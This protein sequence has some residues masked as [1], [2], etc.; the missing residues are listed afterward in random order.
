[1]ANLTRSPS[2]LKQRL[3]RYW[4]GYP[5]WSSGARRNYKSE[6]ERGTKGQMAPTIDRCHSPNATEKG[7][8]L[9]SAWS[10]GH[11][12]GQGRTTLTGS[13]GRGSA[14]L[15]GSMDEGG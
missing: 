7:N 6:P 8:G 3:P 2:P 11:L 12:E 14:G 9:G 10:R 4:P 1:M 13:S 15:A 5:R